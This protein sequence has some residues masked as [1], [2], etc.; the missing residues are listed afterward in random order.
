[1]NGFQTNDAG[2]IIL[3]GVC[4]LC[5]VAIGIMAAVFFVF[6]RFAGKDITSFFLDLLRGERDTTPPPPAIAKPNFRSSAPADFD[7][8]V[9]Q[10]MMREGQ[11]RT[12]SAQ[13]PDAG[14]TPANA[15]SPSS[16]YPAPNSGAPAKPRTAS[17][18]LDPTPS[19]RFDEPADPFSQTY[20][21]TPLVPPH[22]GSPGGDMLGGMGDDLDF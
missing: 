20:P 17:P 7:V 5:V 8:L 9:N 21:Q 12:Y 18:K 10:N 16:G 19:P 14:Q 22:P 13:T 11:P 6:A 1:M 15:P 4:G 3:F 2:M